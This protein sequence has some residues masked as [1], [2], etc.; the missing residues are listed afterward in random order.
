MLR[1]IYYKIVH[2]GLTFVHNVMIYDRYIKILFLIISD[3]NVWCFAACTMYT[4][5]LPLNTIHCLLLNV[6][7]LR[8]I[9]TKLD[10]NLFN[11]N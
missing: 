2:M 9:I 11:S 10:S 8:A 1:I 3:A 5:K 6:I 7:F 4:V